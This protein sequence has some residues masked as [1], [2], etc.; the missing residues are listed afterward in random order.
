MSTPSMTMLPALGCS[1]PASIRSSV[2]LPQPE[3]PRMANSSPR[4]DVERHSIDR[5]DVAEA[6]R[7]FA[8]LHQGRGGMLAHRPVFTRDH[9][10]DRAR[11]SFG[12]WMMPSAQA[13]AAR[14]SGGYTAGSLRTSGSTSGMRL[15]V[16]RS[17]AGFVADGRDHLGP[18]QIVQEQMRVVRMRRIGWNE[19]QIE[20]RQRAFARGGVCQLA[21]ACPLPS[22]GASPAHSRRTSSWRCRPPRWAGRSSIFAELK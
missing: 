6:L 3:L 8:D 22:R 12:L 20:P 17:V 1:N 21:P 7:H 10:R 4:S 18:Q 13:S 16:R 15:D 19:P 11:S 5:D 14:S 9:R 2:V